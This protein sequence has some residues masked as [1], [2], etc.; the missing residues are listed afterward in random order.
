MIL[1]R[2]DHVRVTRALR[3][4][5]LYG[6]QHARDAVWQ[7]YQRVYGQFGYTEWLAYI[8]RYFW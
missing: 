6:V 8:E 5:L 3:A 1:P 4:A 2:E 7:A